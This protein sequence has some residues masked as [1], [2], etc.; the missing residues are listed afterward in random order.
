MGILDRMRL[1]RHHRRYRSVAFP[2]LEVVLI[3][4]AVSVQQS[5]NLA[6]SPIYYCR[7]TIIESGGIEY[8]STRNL[9]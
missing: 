6:E 9:L 3:H 4:I 7:M 1:F 2:A 8:Y 5:G